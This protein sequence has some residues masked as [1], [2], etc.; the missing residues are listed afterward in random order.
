MFQHVG[1]L[2]VWTQIGNLLYSRSFDQLQILIFVSQL[3]EPNLL[4][5]FVKSSLVLS[6]PL[7]FVLHFGTFRMFL[8][9]LLLMDFRH[10]SSLG[11][12]RLTMGERE[13]ADSIFYVFIILTNLLL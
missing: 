10:L 5:H 6:F 1:S 9:V 11:F 8:L 12:D 4:L 7:F 2:V 13:K 3:F